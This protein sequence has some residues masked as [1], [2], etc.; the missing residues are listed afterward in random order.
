MYCI[1]VSLYHNQANRLRRRHYREHST[2]VPLSGSSHQVFHVSMPSCVSPSI[3]SLGDARLESV[4][5]CPLGSSSESISTSFDDVGDVR[6]KSNRF[7]ESTSGSSEPCSTSSNC[8]SEN[9]GNSPSASSRGGGDVEMDEDSDCGVGQRPI[10]GQLWFGCDRSCFL[11]ED[12]VTDTRGSSGGVGSCSLICTGTGVSATLL[13]SE[14][15]R[16]ASILECVFPPRGRD[17]RRL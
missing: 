17:V 7:E 16:A 12:T 13:G 1:T 4:S 2:R 10:L 6:P 5:T 15:R 8:E 3:S 9:D 11:E 14:F